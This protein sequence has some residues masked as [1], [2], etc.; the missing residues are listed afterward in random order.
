MKKRLLAV[1]ICF[2]LMVASAL[3]LS[4]ASASAGEMETLNYGVIAPVT[5]PVAKFGLGLLRAVQIATDR[6]NNN[7]TLGNNGPGILVNGQRYKIKIVS[8]DD[9]FDPAMDAIGLRRLSERYDVK[10]VQG[11]IAVP[12]VMSAMSL[13]VELGILLG[14]QAGSDSLQKTGNPLIIH[15]RI[16]VEWAGI[17]L[18][19][20]AIAQ[21]WKNGCIV[22]DGSNP[23]WV[24]QGLVFKKRFEEL[25]GKILSYEKPDASMTTDYHSIMTKVKAKDPDFIFIS[26]LDPQLAVATL[27]ARDIGYSKPFIFNSELSTETEKVVGLKNLE[28]SVLNIWQYL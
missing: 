4:P 27:H 14:S 7:G 2:S 9:K 17:P 6:I 15:D 8:Y 18:A 23:G 19:E 5:G 10:V 20:G 1:L 25:G 12:H 26:M 3:M 22:A 11:P 13:N 21:G 28:G 24:D 16:G